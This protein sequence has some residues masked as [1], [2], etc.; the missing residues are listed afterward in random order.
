IDV[1]R[2]GEQPF[3]RIVPFIAVFID[4]KFPRVGATRVRQSSNRVLPAVIQSVQV[5]ITGSIAGDIRTVWISDHGS[6][7]LSDD[8]ISPPLD[9]IRDRLPSHS[10]PFCH[11]PDILSTLCPPGPSHRAD[12]EALPRGIDDLWGYRLQPV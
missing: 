12:D 8:I 3:L 7:E 10:C 6:I 5:Q 1:P 9:W 4:C 11:E 2:A